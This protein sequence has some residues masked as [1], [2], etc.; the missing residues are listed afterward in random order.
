MAG[1]LRYATMV[2]NS[3]NTASSRRARRDVEKNSEIC[4]SVM[5][6][7]MMLASLGSDGVGVAAWAKY[8]ASFPV[9]ARRLILVLVSCRCL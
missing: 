6:S 1:S 9:F 7:D 5:E 2:S 3:E 4:W 8:V